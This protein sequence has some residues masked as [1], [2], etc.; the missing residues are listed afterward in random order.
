MPA[1]MEAID[2]MSTAEK[3]VVMNY[4]WASLS[5]TGER[6]VPVW[7]VEGSEPVTKPVKRRVSQYGALKGKVGMSPDFD[8]PLDD[9]AEYMADFSSHRRKVSSPL[10]VMG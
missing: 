3:V 7:H 6:F 10:R 4:L 8:A 1:V 2:Q 9:F 5:S